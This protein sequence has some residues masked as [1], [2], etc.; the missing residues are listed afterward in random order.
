[1]L[2]ALIM[3]LLAVGLIVFSTT[4][5]QLHPFL[6]LLAAALLFGLGSGMPLPLLVSALKEGFGGTIGNVGIII[7]A[8]TAIT[9]VGT[10]WASK[11]FGGKFHPYFYD[12][13]TPNC[14]IAAAGWFLLA[15]YAFD[16]PP[17][18]DIE[19]RMAAASFG[20]YLV[21]VLVI[22]WWSQVGYWQSKIYP[23]A[24]IP[25]MMCMVMFLSYTVIAVLQALPGG[26]RLC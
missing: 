5:W 9:A 23:I 11:T 15:Q 17:L 8:G 22:D 16:R 2:I 4:R 24:G 1:M 21:H 13:L 26:Q 20:I 12:Y 3:L 19:K 7:I 18:L 6:A 10:Y 14:A 25:I